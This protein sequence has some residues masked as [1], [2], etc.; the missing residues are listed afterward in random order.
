MGK[1]IG[2]GG[3]FIKY[4]DEQ[5]M[6]QWYKDALGLMPNDYGVLFSFNGNSHPKAALQLGTFSSKTEYFGNPNQQVMLNF[7][8][9]NLAE[10]QAHLVQFGVKI[11]DDIE[12]Y[13]FG[14]FL[15]IE[16]PEGNRI[17]LWE[18]KGSFSDEIFN[19]MY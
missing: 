6:K 7:R 1:A 18:P 10:L 12:D 11:C 2:I 9:D 14:K 17:E 13:P 16:D 4:Q 15:H 3:I 19:E 5:A 8:V